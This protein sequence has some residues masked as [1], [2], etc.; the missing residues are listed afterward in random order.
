M[1]QFITSNGHK[2]EEISRAMSKEGIE[3]AWN[4][5]NYEEIQADT[6]E[7]ISMDSAQKM[8]RDLSEPFFL[9]D[10]GLYIEQLNGFPGPYSSYVFKTIGNSGILRLMNE[11]NRDARFLTIITYHENGKFY[12]FAGTLEGSIAMEPRGENTFGYDPVF[13]PAGGN[14]TLGEMSV[15][16]KN[17]ISHRWKAVRLFMDHLQKK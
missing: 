12:Q 1:I 13:L 3:I 17:S 6:T 5:M 7:E 2:Y 11:N 9:E 4:R 15:E 16:E 10:T 8:A 14:K